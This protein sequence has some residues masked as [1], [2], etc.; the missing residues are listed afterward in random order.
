MSNYTRDLHG[1]R[2]LFPDILIPESL[3]PK[4]EVPPPTFIIK[5]RIIFPYATSDY[6]LIKLT[7]PMYEFVKLNNKIDYLTR[8]M[9]LIAMDFL[10]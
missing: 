4:F 6:D 3:L 2:T 5:I 7:I 10:L 1:P 9:S 8:I